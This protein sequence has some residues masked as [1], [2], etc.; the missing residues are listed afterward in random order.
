MNA[1]ITLYT[2]SFSQ[3]ALRP[4][5]ALLEKGLPFRKVEVDL[6]QGE[7]QRPP[8]SDLTPR[9]QVPT[10]VYGTGAEDIV[11]YESIATLYFLEDMH[12]EPAL[13]PPLADPRRRA[14][15]HM[16]IAEFQAKL[17]PKNIFGSVA[18]RRQGREQLGS[19]VDD[20]VAELS[21]WDAYLEGQSWLAGDRFTLA[22]IA[23]FPLLMHFEALGF[24]FAAR[25]PALGAYVAR[26]K[27]RPSVQ[28][29][30]W[31]DS[32]AAFVSQRAPEP[33]LAD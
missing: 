9:R 26:C 27:A 5:L 4:E 23:V 33:V 6:L 22:D 10:L 12:P 32:F 11:V 14:L 16:R 21:R 28:A 30:G 7:H 20:L 18:F 15:A 8:L 13:M 31:L 1:S 2:S 3:N 25:T 29:S 24:D 19:R 17:D